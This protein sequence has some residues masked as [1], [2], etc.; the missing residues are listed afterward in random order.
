MKMTLTLA[1]RNKVLQASLHYS[2]STG[3]LNFYQKEP[4][5]CLKALMTGE[6]T[7][8][9]SALLPLGGQEDSLHGQERAKQF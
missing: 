2:N 8:A 6:S 4:N 9:Q 1:Y 3:T 7:T 5:L